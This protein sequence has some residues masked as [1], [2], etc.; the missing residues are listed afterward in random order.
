MNL[1]S[2]IEGSIKEILEYDLIIKE[3][4]GLSL[5]VYFYNKD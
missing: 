2:L 1:R 4:P 5:G 3:I